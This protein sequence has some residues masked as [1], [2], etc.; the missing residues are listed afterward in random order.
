MG[1]QGHAVDDPEVSVLLNA[2]VDQTTAVY[3]TVDAGDAF[4]WQ[5]GAG[6]ESLG[7]TVPQTA[8]DGGTGSGTATFVDTLSGPT[9]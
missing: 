3:A 6:Y 8:I 9:T 7:A 1:L 4:Q 2:S 5:A